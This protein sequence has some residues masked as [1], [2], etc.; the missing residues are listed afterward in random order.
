MIE[1]FKFEIAKF[2]SRRLILL[3]FILT[4]FAFLIILKIG[5]YLQIAS[6]KSPDGLFFTI[7]ANAIIDFAQ[8]Y[9]FLPA[10][11]IILI[12]Y[13]FSNGHVNRVVFFKS[14]WFYFKAK[15][16]YC[17]AISI[18]FSILSLFALILVIKTSS[19]NWVTAPGITYFW[20]FVQCLITYSSCSVLSLGIVFIVKSPFIGFFIYMLL[21]LLDAIA[22]IYHTEL[23]FLPFHLARIF[24]SKGR[25]GS[26]QIHFNPFAEG[27]F[28]L[29]HYLHPLYFT[30]I[31]VAVF[32][33]F[34]KN[35]LKPLS[36]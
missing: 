32:F 29:Q 28:E 6:G 2:L 31:L 11:I 34:K 24:Y 9:L 15:L 1:A 20:F 21:E 12:G 8:L 5:S 22:T 4:V 10:W 35:D 33:H 16:A 23:Y 25:N 18:C 7:T 14:K 19:L 17:F 30:F 36:D 3:L 27:N 26:T 13:E